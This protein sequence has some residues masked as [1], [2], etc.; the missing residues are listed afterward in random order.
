MKIEKEEFMEIGEEEL[1]VRHEYQNIKL[2]KER[3]HDQKVLHNLELI[4]SLHVKRLDF[5]LAMKKASD[6]SFATLRESSYEITQ[7]EYKLQDAWKFSRDS[8]WHYNTDKPKCACYR[9]TSIPDCTIHGSFEGLLLI[10]SP[11]LI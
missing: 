2:N 7:I 1:W 3:L 9:R 11:L 6:N 8:R 10:D 4:K 5:L